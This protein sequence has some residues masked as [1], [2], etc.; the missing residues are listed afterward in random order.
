MASYDGYSDCRS[1]EDE[2]DGRSP[3]YATLSSSQSLKHLILTGDGNR[4]D[5]S[6]LAPNMNKSEPIASLTEQG[7]RANMTVLLGIGY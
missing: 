4:S 1:D 6:H 5:L 2:D 3:V 7:L